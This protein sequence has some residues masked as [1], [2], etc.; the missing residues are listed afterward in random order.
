MVGMI[1][2]FQGDKKTL[3]CEGVTEYFYLKTLFKDS[4][5]VIPST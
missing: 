2:P 5:V 1:N 3:I 4:F